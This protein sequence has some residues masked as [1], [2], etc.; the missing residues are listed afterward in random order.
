MSKILLIADDEPYILY[1]LSMYL[2]HQQFEIIA[3]TS[4]DDIERKLADGI[5]DLF[6]LDIN[7]G[8]DDGREIC[9]KLKIA[10]PHIP[11]ILISARPDLISAAKMSGADAYIEKPFEFSSFITT[12]NRLLSS[13]TFPT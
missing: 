3:A 10:R 12:I 8:T 1:M 13:K 2:R 6:I 9:K 5:P 7:L 11:V 4:K